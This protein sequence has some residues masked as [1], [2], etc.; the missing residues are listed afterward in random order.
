[1]IVPSTTIVMV[2]V[3]PL[4]MLNVVLLFT[5][6]GKSRLQFSFDSSFKYTCAIVMVHLKS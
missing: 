1:V 2:V 3:A 6:F 4:M 5:C